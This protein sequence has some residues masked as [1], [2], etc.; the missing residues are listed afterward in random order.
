MVGGARW[1]HDRQVP[2]RFLAFV[3]IAGLLGA[4]TSG[5]ADPT[6]R[7]ST[8]LVS[9]STS[10]TAPAPTPTGPLTTGPNV[11]P[12]ERPPVLPPE[13]KKHTGSGATLFAAYFFKAFSWG[14]SVNDPYLVAKISF[15]RC[16]ACAKYIRSLRTLRRSGGQLFGGHVTVRSASLSPGVQ[17]EADYAVDVGIDEQPVI[18]MYPHAH[19]STAAPAE[20][21]HHSV[22]FLK[23]IGGGWKVVEMEAAK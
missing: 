2:I 13:A 20:K 23:W 3:L 4:C 5:G 14:Y 6:P 22:V 7:P 21:G 15:P 1:C 17:Y 9:S 12:G 16:T 10:G 8:T 18:L 11:R 19:P